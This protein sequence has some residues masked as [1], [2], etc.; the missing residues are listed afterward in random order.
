MADMTTTEALRAWEAFVSQNAAVTTLETSERFFFIA[1]YV[2]ALASQ[3]QAAGAGGDAVACVTHE[4]FKRS[5]MDCHVA[6]N[7]RHFAAAPAVEP[8]AVV[9]DVF[10]EMCLPETPPFPTIGK[11]SSP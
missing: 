7:Y 10:N 5:C 4:R 9:S 8:E 6:D 3:P 11:R 1:G 2:A